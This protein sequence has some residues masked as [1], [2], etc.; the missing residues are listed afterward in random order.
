MHED[1][2][3]DVLGVGPL[4][5]GDEHAVDGATVAAI[6]LSERLAVAVR[7]GVHQG[8]EILI[9]PHAVQ[10]DARRGWSVNKTGILEAVPVEFSLVNHSFGYIISYAS[11]GR[12]LVGW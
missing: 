10:Q 1:V 8:W 9:G 11:F 6:Q 12:M 4:E 5:T 2:V 3:H 7:G